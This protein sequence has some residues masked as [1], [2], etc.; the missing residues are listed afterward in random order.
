MKQRLIVAGAILLILVIV[1]GYW[2]GTTD[3]TEAIEELDE[4]IEKQKEEKAD[5]NTIE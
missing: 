3:F 4:A 1:A 5:E 2:M